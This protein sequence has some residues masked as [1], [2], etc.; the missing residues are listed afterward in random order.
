M[1]LHDSM[2]MF[3]SQLDGCTRFLSNAKCTQPT[4]NTFTHAA[5]TFTFTLYLNGTVHM[6]NNRQCN[7]LDLCMYAEK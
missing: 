5:K 4:G 7:Q 3:H 1:R 6:D 2:C